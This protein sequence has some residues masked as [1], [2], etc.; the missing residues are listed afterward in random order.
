MNKQNNE[1]VLAGV[2]KVEI[3]CKAGGTYDAMLSEKTKK[4]I[5]K[6]YLGTPLIVDDPLFV[7]ALVLDDGCRK[8]VIITMDVT[9]I[10]ARTVSQN[11]L[12]DSADD[13][14]PQLRKQIEAELHIPGANVSVSASHTHQV[15]RM[16]CDDNEQISRTIA[17]I[18]QALKN[19]KP[20]IIG[21]GRGYEN[22]LTI[23]RTLMMKDGTDYTWRPSPP[24]EEIEGLRPIDPEIGI[25]RIDQ[26]D[27]SPLA[28]VY[29]F[30]SHLLLGSP[31]GNQGRVTADHVGVTL[32]LL[33]DSLGGNVMAFFLQGAHGDIVEASW[34]DTN[35]IYK[36][37][38][39]GIKLGQKI[40]NAYRNIKPAQKKTEIKMITKN[41]DFP[42]RSDIP[43]RI[44]Q[45][46]QQQDLLRKSLDTQYANLLSFD[47]FLPLYL[48]YSLNP[49][50]PS[51]LPN[52]YM[53]ADSCG[54][55]SIKD[56]DDRNRL[57]I[58]KYLD[59]IRI[60]EKMTVNEIKISILQRHQEIID[61]IGTKTI[62]A[63]IKGIKIGECIFIV[64]PMEVLS[65]IGFKIKKISSFKHTYIVS[66]SN[67]YLHYSPP[68]SYYPRG[69]YEVTECLLAP[70]W[71]KIFEKTVKEIFALLANSA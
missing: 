12:T 15:A 30:A 71:E 60:M 57:E 2:G 37:R 16:L 19:M 55:N 51:H 45:L 40:L 59:R 52:R 13:F 41:I 38:D 6:E 33:E 17:A 61:E 34:E 29:N 49:D 53:Q 67:G 39:F 31:L 66:I 35:N 27:G 9:A 54:D 47:Y 22:S 65:E 23:N 63:E 21:V 28:I 50:Y 25:L 14:M 11:I 18:K 62:P 3:T 10:G 46:N 44:S 8:I 56:E 24:H 58:K 68:A 42:F 4:Y 1:Y 64:A 20:V 32:K 26:L 7:R 70:E 36:T 48:R 69:G 43:K 5:P